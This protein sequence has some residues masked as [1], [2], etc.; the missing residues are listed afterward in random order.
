MSSIILSFSAPP[1][2]LI[3]IKA[4][5][6]HVPTLLPSKMKMIAFTSPAICMF[7][8]LIL[9]YIPRMVTVSSLYEETNN[10]QEHYYFVT[11][12]GHI[13]SPSPTTIVWTVLP[14]APLVFD[15]Y[16][17]FAHLHCVSVSDV[18]CCSPICLQH[19]Y[20][21]QNQAMPQVHPKKLLK[22]HKSTVCHVGLQFIWLA[23]IFQHTPKIIA[24]AAQYA[25]AKSDQTEPTLPVTAMTSDQVGHGIPTFANAATGITDLIIK[26]S[27]EHN[28][29]IIMSSP[30]VFLWHLFYGLLA[31]LGTR[32]LIDMC[33]YALSFYR[34]ILCGT[35][36]PHDSN[37]YCSNFPALK[38]VLTIASRSLSTIANIFQLHPHMTGQ[39]DGILGSL[40]NGASEMVFWEHDMLGC[41]PT[42]QYP[43]HDLVLP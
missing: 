30:S 39:W 28:S 13:S 6:E 9:L 37:T 41:S 27:I 12:F 8:I 29:I 43:L 34:S 38:S 20:L 26:S 32:R 25:L 14:Y 40:Y 19:G 31:E 22:S 18:G 33:K 11:A 35:I 7:T 15:V 10:T 1:S 23:D 4:L 42:N 16:K 17:E 3:S 36:E 24:K 5:I 2:T 21:A